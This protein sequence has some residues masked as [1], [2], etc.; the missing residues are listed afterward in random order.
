MISLRPDAV[1]GTSRPIPLDAFVARIERR[2]AVA[3]YHPE[4]QSD[5]GNRRTASTRALLKAIED[6]GGAW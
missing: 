3:G 5:A 2:R 4:M 6:A 1:F